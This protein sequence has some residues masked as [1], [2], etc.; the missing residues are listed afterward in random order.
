MQTG[1]NRLLADDHVE[2]FWGPRHLL[3]FRACGVATV[4]TVHDFWDRYHPSQQP[5]LNRRVNRL[6]IAR[7]IAHADVVVAPSDATARDV[8]RFVGVVPGG[9]RVV[10][11][12]VDPMVFR[13]LPAEQ[14]AGVLAR[15]GINSPYL[16]SLDVFNPRK[17]FFAVLEGV[18]KLP[19]STRKALT[20]VGVSGRRR[21]A[22]A[23]DFPARAAALGLHERLRLIG[24]VAPEDL[25]ALYSGALAL[26]Y[27]SVYEGFG[28]PVL[29]AMACGC[30]VITSDRSSLPEVAGDAAL[31]IDPTSPEQIARAISLVATDGGERARLAVAGSAWVEGFTW[32]RT[33]EE[34]M[35][36]F[37][38][39]LA[40]RRARP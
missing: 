40:S 8:T 22:P 23:C 3:P 17:N 26:V 29:E 14:V 38:Q 18:A 37:E 16:L 30:P 4:A 9:V 6:L 15:L 5:W 13:P 20:V 35:A 34:M 19:E 10:P 1:V 24:D 27:P 31:L 39:A 32:R 33:A 7:V 25:V 11:W 28:M 36:A 12:G 2:V 21:T